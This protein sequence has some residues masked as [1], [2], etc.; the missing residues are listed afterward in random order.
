MSK[1]ILSRLT[2]IACEN[3]TKE[4]EKIVFED[5]AMKNLDI[6]EFNNFNLT[7]RLK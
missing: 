7:E 4:K 5:T 3:Y 1:T 2:V 6:D